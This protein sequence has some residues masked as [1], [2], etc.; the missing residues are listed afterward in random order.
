MYM[1]RGATGKAYSRPLY[2]HPS[3][4]G[5]HSMLSLEMNEIYLASYTEND[6]LVGRLWMDN[7]SSELSAG[8]HDLKLTGKKHKQIFSA[9]GARHSSLP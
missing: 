9:T 1:K 4:D 3:L 6:N 5:A 7:K 8:N 2:Q